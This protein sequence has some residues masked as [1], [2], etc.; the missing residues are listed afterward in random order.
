M[1]LVDDVACGLGEVNADV[2]GGDES[3]TIVRWKYIT[4]ASPPAHKPTKNVITGLGQDERVL[5][6]EPRHVSMTMPRSRYI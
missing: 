3:D 4:K 5:L 1:L 2:G 6:D